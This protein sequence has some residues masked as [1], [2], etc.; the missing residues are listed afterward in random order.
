MS[1]EWLVRNRWNFNSGWIIHL[2]SQI[3]LKKSFIH[4][5]NISSIN[6]WMNEWI[7]LFSKLS[8]FKSIC[9]LNPFLWYN[10]TLSDLLDIISSRLERA[11]VGE[12]ADFL[13]ETFEVSLGVLKIF[14]LLI[15]GGCRKREAVPDP[16]HRGEQH[17]RH[18]TA[19][20]KS[21]RPWGQ[22]GKRKESLSVA[23]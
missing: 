17:H 10:R 14:V 3:I 5:L 21:L 15:V 2:I 16:N 19:L 23:N 13:V 6:E 9:W 22:V 11:A 12:L 18:L 4:S 8:V 1:P 7:N 20:P